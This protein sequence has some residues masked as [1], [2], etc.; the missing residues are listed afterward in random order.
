MKA[1]FSS[2]KQID[3]KPIDN[4]E[5]VLLEHMREVSNN[6]LSFVMDE[7]YG[8]ISLVINEPKLISENDNLA[9][10][11]IKM[12]FPERIREYLEDHKILTMKDGSYIE[13]VIAYPEPEAPEIKWEETGETGE[14]TKDIKCTCGMV[15]TVDEAMS[16]DDASLTTDHEEEHKEYFL[17]HYGEDEEGNKP[18][19]D[20]NKDC[21]K[22]EVT[23]EIPQGYYCDPT[24]P[25]GYRKCIPGHIHG[26]TY[27]WPNCC[28]GMMNGANGSV[29]NRT[30][31]VRLV[32]EVLGEVVLFSMV[33][34]DD[35]RINTEL[36]KVNTTNDMSVIEVNK[37]SKFYDCF[38]I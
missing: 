27:M 26:A 7:K 4:N 3:F 32:S 29:M 37:H 38:K 33:G 13:C 25:N 12:L 1:T 31:I 9:G 21:C 22:P 15:K 8:D 35:V 17:E 18:G 14:G 23:S 6:Q 20:E 5:K 10:K 16:L 11:V 24:A 36:Y 2:T 28:N 30:I 34:V 19:C